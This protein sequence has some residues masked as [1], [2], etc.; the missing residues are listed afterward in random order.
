[1]LTYIG[2]NRAPLTTIESDIVRL[3]Q[4]N[5]AGLPS[6]QIK[7]YLLSTS[8][9]YTQSN[10]SKN[11]FH[12]PLVSI[13]KTQGRTKYVFTLIGTTREPEQ[14]SENSDNRYWEFVKKL[15]GLE[16]TDETISGKRRREQPLLREWLFSNKQIC[17]CAICGKEYNISA[18][19]TA[20]KKKRN[21]C[22]YT[23]RTDPYIVM[24]LC[25]F[26]CDYLYENR[27]LRINESGVVGRGVPLT[28]CSFE[29]TYVQQVVNRAVSSEWL[30][31]PSSYF[32]D[33]RSEAPLEH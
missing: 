25:V 5:S 14:R 33:G 10:I 11:I 20:H 8:N 32:T 13:D 15:R 16:S 3:L 9:D 4:H 31:G 30:R 28:D 12:S 17:A 22:N 23:E 19:M 1:M 6:P 7:E 27:Y 29:E 2:E 26:G 18:L 21:Q 24:P